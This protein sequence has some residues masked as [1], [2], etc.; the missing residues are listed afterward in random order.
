[1]RT[2]YKQ[3]HKCGSWLFTWQWLWQSG[4]KKEVDHTGRELKLLYPP[5]TLCSWHSGLSDRGWGS[6]DNFLQRLHS[7][8]PERATTPPG[9]GHAGGTRPKPAQLWNQSTLWKVA[10]WPWP[11]TAL[12]PVLFKCTS[13]LNWGRTFFSGI[14]IW[15]P[16]A[17]AQCKYISSTMKTVI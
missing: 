17:Y 1:M 5:P 3:E 11:R 16:G 14:E 9:E 6:L 4:H 12:T 10:M 7:Q 15:H 2:L 8:E 13:A